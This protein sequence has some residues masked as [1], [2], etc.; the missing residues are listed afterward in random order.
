MIDV[1][2]RSMMSRR[3]D[4]KKVYTVVIV[5]NIFSLIMMSLLEEE[6]IALTS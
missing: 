4:G 1:E 5:R 3:G 2:Y 6:V